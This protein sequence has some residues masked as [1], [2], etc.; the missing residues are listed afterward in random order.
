MDLIRQE[1][2]YLNVRKVYSQL[3][4][5]L[6]LGGL[7]CLL[8]ASSPFF[9]KWDNIR[10]ILDQ[11]TINIIMAVGMTLVICSGGIDLSI[12][13]V[14]ALTGTVVAIALHAGVPVPLAM[15][16][17]LGLGLATG[18]CNGNLIALLHLNP[19]IVTLA[20]LSVFRG[21]TLIVTGS[22]PIYGFP[23]SF[24]WYGSGSIG[25]FPVPVIITAVIAAAGAGILKHTKLGYY[26]LALGGNM[27]ALR[28]SGV[29]V[30]FYQSV[31]YALSGLMASDAGLIITARLNSADP[32]AGSMMELD[33]IATVI[34]GGTSMKGGR[35]SITGTTIAGLLL[36]VLRNGLTINGIAS[37]YQQLLTGLIII[38]AVGVSEL[39]SRREITIHAPWERKKLYIR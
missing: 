23:D 15:V 6:V 7:I 12:G 21:L 10:N 35:G 19:F 11:S 22:I 25:I 29:S 36:A 17:G 9:L 20:T 34:L 30:N 13:A 24:L 26:T 3:L 8:T 31:V 32:T 28:R 4:L 39:R 5:L 2:K 14:A 18:I 27:E 38:I 37:Y 1:P 16:A 33:A